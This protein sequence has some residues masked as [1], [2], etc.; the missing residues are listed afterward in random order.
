[1]KI[2]NFTFWKLSTP[3]VSERIY[4]AQVRGFSFP[5]MTMCNI[6]TDFVTVYNVFAARDN[7]GITAGKIQERWE[8]SLISRPKVLQCGVQ[9]I[10]W[11]C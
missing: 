6:I 1:M 11:L 2:W 5:G 4:S 9:L 3:N 7:L 10:D 8:K